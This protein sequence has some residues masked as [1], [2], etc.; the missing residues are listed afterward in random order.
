MLTVISQR[1]ISAE[2]GADR[3][4][5]EQ[6]Y[7]N[8]YGQFGLNLIPLSNV[9]TNL[10]DYLTKLPIE[11]I[12]LSGGNDVNP[13]LYGE[14]VTFAKTF[15]DERDNTE[16][17]L[18][19]YAVS[20]KIPVLGICRGFQF[21]N[22]YFGGKLTQSLKEEAKSDQNHV[23]TQHNVSLI[24]AQETQIEVLVN[25]FHNSGIICDD[26]ADP[27]EI[28]A[29]CTV[30]GTVEGLRHRKYPIAGIMWHPEREGGDREINKDLV[31]QFVNGKG[32]WGK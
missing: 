14:P 9:I 8:Y 15:S 13:S 17:Q 23:A 25:S 4:G 2:K 7:V 24:T 6:D 28:I 10:E 5:L 31:S 32:Y 20:N 29:Q 26:V 16:N 12:I 18:L 30:D 1:V 11:R 19:D 22:V 27:L 21:I 3:D